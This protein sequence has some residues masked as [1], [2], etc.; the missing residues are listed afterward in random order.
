M[1]SCILMAQIIQNPELRYTS[2]NQTPIAQM[3]VQFDSLR[4]EEAPIT[5][6]VVGWG[7]F[8]TEIKENYRTG[9]QVV[10]EGSLRMNVIDRSEGFKEKR[11][12]LTAYRIHKLAADANFESPVSDYSPS[13]DE[14]NSASSKTSDNVVM[15]RTNRSSTPMSEDNDLERDYETTTQPTFE[16]TRVPNQTAANSESE[17]DLDDIPF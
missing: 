4:A 16:P 12:E 13:V 9:D 3:L 1:N 14:H 11:A 7:N 5:L 6:K 15:L 17:Q 2:D 8:A 10:I